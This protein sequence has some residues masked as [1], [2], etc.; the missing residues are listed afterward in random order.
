M[1]LL[2]DPAAWMGGAWGVGDTIIL[3]PGERGL[4]QVSA[5]RGDA[6]DQLT[7]PTAPGQGPKRPKLLPGG[8]GLVFNYG[9]PPNSRIVIFDRTTRSS[10]VLNESGDGPVYTSSGHLV[11]LRGRST[12]M[13]MPFD[14]ERLTP[15]REPVA[16]LEGVRDQDYAISENGTLAYVPVEDGTG[17]RASAKLVW[18]SR[19]GRVVGEAVSE[20]LEDPRDMRISPEG[21]RLAVVTGPPEDGD[22]WVHDFGG[23][24]PL[25]LFDGA[26]NSAPVWSPDGKRVAFAS[27]G[28]AMGAYPIYWMHADGSDREPH[29][30]YSGAIGAWPSSWSSRDLLVSAFVPGAGFDIRAASLD[31]DASSRAVIASSGI[32]RAAQVSSDGQWFAYESNRSGQIDVWVQG[33]SGGPPTRVSRGGGVE[34]VIGLAFIA[35]V[36][37]VPCLVHDDRGEPQ[38]ALPVSE[39]S[40]TGAAE[41]SA[42]RVN[43]NQAWSSIIATRQPGVRIW[44]YVLGQGRRECDRQRGD[45]RS[46]QFD[47][48]G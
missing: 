1:K 3:A 41:G 42:F 19:A 16:V 35:P 38:P 22:L 31:S 43:D 39:R 40:M 26:N 6:P 8:R 46:G 30:A 45:L 48:L 20:P 2:D 32:E 9:V 47:R 10:R 24:P 12:L 33:Y 11:F 21:G 15:T 5:G 17:Q 18:R 13:A 44:R 28:A 36:P 14:L 7:N 29:P 4:L 25:R 37:E 23:R 27:G 34:G